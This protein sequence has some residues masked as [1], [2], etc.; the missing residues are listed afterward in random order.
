MQDLVLWNQIPINSFNIYSSKNLLDKN[1]I[2]DG[3]NK[4]YNYVTRTD[5]NNGIHSKIAKQTVELNDG[6]CLTIGLDTQTVFYQEESFYTGQNVHI[7][8]IKNAN[9]YVY[10]FIAT[11]LKKKIKEMYSWGGNGATLGR[12]KQQELLLPIKPNGN[13]DLEYMEQYIKSLPYSKYL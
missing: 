3:R 1:K 10:L 4:V 9:K 2:I 11:I 8:R 12:L 6:N 7:L 5:I 13:L